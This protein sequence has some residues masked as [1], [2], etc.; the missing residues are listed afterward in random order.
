MPIEG[1]HGNAINPLFM[2]THKT[3]PLD[4][5]H[6]L[7]SLSTIAAGMPADPRFRNAHTERSTASHGYAFVIQLHT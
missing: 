7:S 5:M 2:K 1:L 6:V 3:L 4:C